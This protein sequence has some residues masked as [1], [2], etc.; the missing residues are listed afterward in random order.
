MKIIVAGGRNF[1]DYELLKEKLDYFLKDLENPIIISGTCK[2]ADKLGER[3]AKENNLRLE[4][5]P[6]D[7]SIG[8]HAGILRNVEMSKVAD[9]LVAFYDGESKGT[10]HMISETKKRNLKVK[11]VYYES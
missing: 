5:F 8:K 3:Y 10:K 2:G 4:L 9:G 7:W 11:V 1:E 6:A